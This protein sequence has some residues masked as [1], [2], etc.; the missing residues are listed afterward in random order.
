M[1]VG[2]MPPPYGG[3]NTLV[4][5]YMEAEYESLRVELFDCKEISMSRAHFFR[6]M[7]ASGVTLARL[8]RRIWLSRPDVVLSF[9]SAGMSFVEKMVWG[10]PIR[11]LGA[12]YAALMVD[13]H[14]PR[15]YAKMSGVARSCF[16][17]LARMPD[18]LFAQSAVWKRYYEAFRAPADVIEL[19]MGIDTE[20]FRYEDRVEANFS[21]GTKDI[22]YVGWM[23][24]EKGV[25]DLLD[26][27]A[28]A[29]AREPALRL[30]LV[31][32]DIGDGFERACADGHPSVTFWGKVP[33]E[34]L[35][36]LARRALFVV[37]P[38]HAEGMPNILLEM[39]AMGV[40]VMATPV[41]GIVDIITDGVD[42]VL[43]PAQEP[44]AWADAM[45]ALSRDKDKLKRLAAR[46]ADR[47]RERH[48]K[49]LVTDSLERA[50]LAVLGRGAGS[51]A[52]AVSSRG[53]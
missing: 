9:P 39:M 32:P 15:R 49:D 16:R 33:D 21:S 1:I 37:L 12:K 44:R 19:R 28:L 23:L 45:V 27:F 50:V 53:R 51:G 5:F 18:Y 26:A 17:L 30:H 4:K 38:S 36:E 22:L 10:V 48:G 14:F 11:F 13:G 42:G 24:R 25:H 40:P 52:Q 41:G 7:L 31:G 46:A 2:T 47:I 35:L 6:R 3:V 20:R 43:V 8:L 34:K 29:S